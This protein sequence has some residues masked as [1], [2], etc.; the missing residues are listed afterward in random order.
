[1]IEF[2][3]FNYFM[4]NNNYYI[5]LMFVYLVDYLISGQEFAEVT[6][7]FT[8]QLVMLFEYYYYLNQ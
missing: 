8:F 7:C 2:G 1:M 6:N 3:Q 4:V 5:D